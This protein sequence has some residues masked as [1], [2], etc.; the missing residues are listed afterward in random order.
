MI[1]DELAKQLHDK[2]TR[3]KSLSSEEQSSLEQW[4]AFQDDAETQTLANYRSQILFR[5]DFRNAR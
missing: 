5:N 1:S 4:S 2:S 3:G